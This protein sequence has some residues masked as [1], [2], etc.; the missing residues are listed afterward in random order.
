MK[1]RLMWVLPIIVIVGAVVFVV[2]GMKPGQAEESNEPVDAALV[3]AETQFGFDL[4]TKLAA[5]DPDKN[6]FIS[7]ASISLALSM[8]YNGAAGKSKQA[9][10]DV[11][12]FKGMSLEQVNMAN[13]A[14]LANLQGPGPGVE[15]QIANSLWARNDVDF[16]RDFLRANRDYYDAEV[17]TLHFSDSRAPDIINEWVSD[18]TGDRI[19]KIIRKINSAEILYLVNAI[20]F[21]G[22]WKDPF[23]PEST[24]ES[25]FTLPNGDKK[26]VPMMVHMDDYDYL[27]TDDFQAIGIPYGNGRLSMYIF[28][29]YRELGLAGFYKKL[30]DASWKKWIS[31]M[32]ECEGTLYLPRFKAEYEVDL[33]ECLV[34]LGMGPAFEFS[35]TD[36]LPMTPAPQVGIGKVL[37]KTFLEVN[38]QGTEAAAS[39]AVVMTTR[40]APAAEPFEMVINRPFFCAIR[41]NK[42]G[43][44]LFVGSIVDPQ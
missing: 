29:P 37:H 44:L 3:K 15:L 13:A 2:I 21:K 31:S 16:E 1:R 39:T 8:T 25:D 27:Q 43:V 24:R 33:K 30:N 4:L 28:L 38:E 40:C 41:D 35:D 14:M 36:W 10:A 12:G 18:N 20:Y 32:R 9:M 26:K 42:T 22:D 11:L 23:K 5:N 6:I 19:K 7:P 34:A 17:R